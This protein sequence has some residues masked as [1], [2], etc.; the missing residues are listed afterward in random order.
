MRAL[1]TILGISYRGVDALSS[2]RD[3]SYHLIIRAFDLQAIKF[4]SINSQ[5]MLY[6]NTE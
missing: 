4:A 6:N 5:R 3:R 1:G 2:Q